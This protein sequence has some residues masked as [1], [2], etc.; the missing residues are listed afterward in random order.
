[1]PNRARRTLQDVADAAGLSLAATSYALRGARGSAATIE[2]V[3]ALALE[4]GYR[5]DPI[6]RA[7]ASGRTGTV[8]ISG[9]LRD[10]WQQDLS[11]MLTRALRAVDRDA[12]IADADADPAVERRVVERFAEQ[13]VDGVLVSPVDPSADYWS[14]LPP[15][16]AVVSIGD[17]LPGRPGSGAVLFDNRHGVTT[18]LRHLRD[19]GHRRVALLTTS[20]PTTPGR[21]AEL[22]AVEAAQLLGLDLLVVPATAARAAAAA[23]GPLTAPDRPTAVLCLSDSLAFGVYRAA[24]DLGLRIPGDLS[25]VGFDDHQLAALVAP[26]LTTAAWDED[27]VVEAA[28]AQLLALEGGGEVPAPV[29]FR[30][31]LVV[32]SSTGPPAGAH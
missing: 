23:D 1:M 5:V 15:P 27:A 21:P 10:L 29:T 20:L 28:V 14:A 26:G 9:S 13:R 7:L 19:L 30:P 18:A 24:A 6:A 2:R 32:R 17:A 25:V 12:T 3:Q 11:V 16:T 22:H 4:L 8:G 31:D